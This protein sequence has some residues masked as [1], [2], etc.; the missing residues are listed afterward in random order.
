ME[1]ASEMVLQA[2]HEQLRITEIP[3]NYHKRKEKSKLNSFSDGWRHLR[4]MLM[5][6]SRKNEVLKNIK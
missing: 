6:A 3:I 5:Y 1:F 4:F 2:M